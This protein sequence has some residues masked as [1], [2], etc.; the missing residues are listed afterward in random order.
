MWYVLIIHIG[1]FLV[2]YVVP[3]N[4]WLH[5]VC[6]QSYPMHHPNVTQNYAWLPHNVDPSLPIP[7]SLQGLPLQPLGNRQSFY[8]DNIQGCIRHYAATKADRR[9]L[10]NEHI[11]VEM[12]LRQPKSMINY[13][14][15]GYTKMK[16]PDEVMR[17]L[18][19]F[20][21]AN[22]HLAQVENW[23]AGNT[24]TNHWKM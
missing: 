16:A 12:S 6:Q 23:S 22:K 11:R 4:F 19:E 24:Y 15:V 14:E 5:N 2:S 18:Q 10:H 20:W 8:N 17:L 21:L 9:C 13:T 3:N 7:L 1:H